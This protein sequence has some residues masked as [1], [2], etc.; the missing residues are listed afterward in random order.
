MFWQSNGLQEVS[1]FQSCAVT[2]ELLETHGVCFWHGKHVQVINSASLTLDIV[3]AL[4][5]RSPVQ[6]SRRQQIHIVWLLDSTYQTLLKSSS[7]KCSSTRIVG[8]ACL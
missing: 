6:D 1:R 4:I 7:L 8:E 2:K 3:V 5:A